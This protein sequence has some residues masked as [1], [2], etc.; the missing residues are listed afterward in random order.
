MRK[1]LKVSLLVAL[2]CALMQVAFTSC[3]DSD[4][5]KP[6]PAPEPANIPQYLFIYVKNE[7]G[8]NLL[9]PETSGNLVGELEGNL[10]YD[11]K[12]YPINWDEISKPCIHFRSYSD[13]TKFYGLFYET[14]FLRNYSDRRYGLV[15]GFFSSLQSW[16]KNLTLEFPQY[17]KAYEIEWKLRTMD[18]SHEP[19][20]DYN[21]NTYMSDL[22]INGEV[23]LTNCGLGTFEYTV[24]LPDKK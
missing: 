9:N 17:D 5:P 1:F 2:F 18:G 12:V 22:I 6:A 15:V 7:S 20:A 19:G 21:F 4:D 11:E 24:V 3:S 10:K 16:N 8:E 23:I 14:E 13:R